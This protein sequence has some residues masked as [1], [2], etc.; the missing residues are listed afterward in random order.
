MR[1]T[2]SFALVAVVLSFGATLFDARFAQAAPCC[3]APVCMEDPDAC[4]I[5][6]DCVYEEEAV[7]SS[8]E[9]SGYDEAAGI[10]YAPVDAE[11]TVTEDGVD[12]E[13]GSDCQ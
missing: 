6:R 7:S 11:L 9:E 13:Q 12:H 1:F 4:K 2:Q 3:S 10:C 8:V 5:C